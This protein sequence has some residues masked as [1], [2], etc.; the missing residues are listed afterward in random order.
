[1]NSYNLECLSCNSNVEDNYDITCSC[2]MNGFY[3]TNY[4]N[5][6]FNPTKKD[7]IWKFHEWLPVVKPPE[8]QNNNDHEKNPGKTIVYK[9]RGLAK[10]LGL[11]NLFIAFNGYWPER[12]A[13]MRTGSFKGLEAPTTIRRAKENGINKLLIATAGNT[14]RAFAE[15]TANQDFEIIIVASESASERLWTT[16]EDING[17]VKLLTLSN[18]NDYTNAIELGK[19]ICNDLKINPEG[20]ARNVARRDGMGTC[21]LESICEMKIAPRHYFQAVGS[22]TG[23]IATWEAAMR[24][25]EDGRFGDYLPRLHLAQNAKFDPIVKAWKAKRKNIIEEDISLPSSEMSS[26]YA[27]V[28]ANRTPPYSITGG[29][30]DALNSTN[31]NMYSISEEEARDAYKMVEQT[32]E[33]DIL[34]PAAVAVASLIKATVEKIINPQDRILLNITGGGIKRIKED[35]DMIPIQPRANLRNSKIDLSDISE[36]CLN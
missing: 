21:Y 33:I 16:S 14:G 9:S 36:L 23:G 29:V 1:M 5:K 28:L 3:R 12:K 24:I 20:G 18:G 27:E 35:F 30:F 34:P 26:L 2:G 10:E 7:N 31:G 22:G 11:E 6:R 15:E 25:R 32:E 8:N 4:L 17:N 13:N 19:R